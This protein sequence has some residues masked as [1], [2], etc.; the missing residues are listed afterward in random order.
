MATETNSRS[1][2][3]FIS[4]PVISSFITGSIVFGITRQ[5]W[6]AFV[7][8]LFDSLI[9]TLFYFLHERVWTVIPYGRVLHPLEERKIRKTLTDSDK[10]VIQVTLSELRLAEEHS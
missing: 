1:L 2:V 10:Q 5:G 7:I 6:I 8:A 9:K 3:K 4:Y